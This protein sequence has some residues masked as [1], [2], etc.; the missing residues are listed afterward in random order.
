[1]TVCTNDVALCNLGEHV[2][3]VAA[4][5]TGCDPELLVPK[6]VELQNDGVGL[7]AVSARVIAK[8]GDE[9]D[10]ALFKLRLRPSGGGVDV[11]LSVGPVV[12]L[13]VLGLSGPT[14]GLPLL[15]L[16]PMP[17]EFLLRFLRF[18]ARA[19]LHSRDHTK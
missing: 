11:S 4:S 19:Q 3:P 12:L 1:V 13:L 18:A 15:A 8:V 9:E 10:Q 16:A 6:M 17:G 2:V 7:S 5:Y 14:I